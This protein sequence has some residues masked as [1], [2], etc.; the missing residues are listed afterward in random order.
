MTSRKFTLVSI[1]ALLSILGASASAAEIS[2]R[3]VPRNHEAIVIFQGK[4]FLG[5]NV[6]FKERTRGLGNNV[7]VFLDSPGGDISAALDIGNFVHTNRWT[8]VVTNGDRCNSACALIWL[9]GVYR[10]LGM[11]ARIGMHSAGTSQDNPPRRNEWGN[12]AVTKYL[13]AIGIDE[14]IVV[15]ATAADPT[16]MQYIEYDEAKSLGLLEK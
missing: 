5:D 15:R 6:E 3:H 10:E 13:Q 4:I 2:V 16:S 11:V 7:F 8:T 9:S 14:R 1:A 12:L